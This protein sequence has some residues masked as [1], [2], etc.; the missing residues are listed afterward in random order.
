MT[1][2]SMGGYSEHQL[3]HLGITLLVC[4]TSCAMPC[5]SSHAV[6]CHNNNAAPTTGDHTADHTMAMYWKRGK[7]R[8]FSRTHARTQALNTIPYSV[9]HWKRGKKIAEAGGRGYSPAGWYVR[10][11]ACMIMLGLHTCIP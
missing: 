11:I 1:T 4:Y 8:E 6:L 2:M 3:P 9:Q 7:R 5:H 10:R